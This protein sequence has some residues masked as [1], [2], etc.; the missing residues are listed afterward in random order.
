MPAV[1]SIDNGRIDT[2][3]PAVGAPR[4]AQEDIEIAPHGVI[5]G[6]PPNDLMRK[7]EGLISAMADENAFEP[8]VLAVYT[9]GYR[10]HFGRDRVETEGL[11]AIRKIGFVDFVGSLA[12]RLPEK[13]VCERLKRGGIIL[14]RQELAREA[15]PWRSRAG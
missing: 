14:R 9:H 11:S 1:P 12:P 6:W 8:V 5:I 7:Y 4:R 10:E 13:G 3:K 15:A 2:E